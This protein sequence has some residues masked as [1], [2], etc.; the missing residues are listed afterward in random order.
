MCSHRLVWYS[1]GSGGVRSSDQSVD[2]HLTNYVSLRAT[3]ISQESVDVEP[4]GGNIYR[5]RAAIANRGA[6]PTYVTNKGKELGRF[7]TV[8]ASLRPAE[9][10]M[11]LSS[12][13]TAAYALDNL[14]P[15]TVVCIKRSL[16]LSQ[17]ILTLASNR[18]NTGHID[19][20]H[21]SA[22]TGQSTAEWFVQATGTSSGNEK[23]CLG[24]LGIRGAAGGDLQLTVRAS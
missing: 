13:G 10:V 4:F 18:V 8:L 23:L 11:L 1:L 9:G 22:V 15:L 5:V 20:G 7:Q 21:L 16:V 2:N 12:E 24:T 14:L 19:L 6:L 17:K 3:L